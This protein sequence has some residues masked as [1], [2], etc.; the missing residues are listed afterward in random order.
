MS[1]QP[2]WAE[3]TGNLPCLFN[4]GNVEGGAVA[5][6]QFEEEYR[7]LEMLGAATR[8]ALTQECSGKWSAF[9]ILSRMRKSKLDPDDPDDDMKMA[10]R[11]LDADRMLMG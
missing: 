8:K 5:S 3:K 9:D 6:L 11:V 7:Y 10:Q 1:N 2:T 4:C